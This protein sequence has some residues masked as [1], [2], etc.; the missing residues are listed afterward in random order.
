MLSQLS[1]N[2]SDFV[3]SSYSIPEKHRPLGHESRNALRGSCPSGCKGRLSRNRVIVIMKGSRHSQ[4]NQNH[5]F[6]LI[7]TLTLLSKPDVRLFKNCNVKTTV[8]FCKICHLEHRILT[9]STNFILRQWAIGNIV[10]QTIH[11]NQ[12]KKFP[13]GVSPIL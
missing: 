6:Q 11:L 10:S 1:F 7:S 5:I 9:Y 4:L 13:P 3:V 12:N 2:P 8:I